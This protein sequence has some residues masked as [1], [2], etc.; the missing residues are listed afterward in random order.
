MCPSHCAVRTFDDPPQTKIHN[1]PFSS[2]H[3]R[4]WRPRPKLTSFVR[5]PYNQALVTE[6]LSI[7]ASQIIMH[8]RHA[9][10]ILTAAL[11]AVA[12]L[13]AFAVAQNAP[14]G[15]PTEPQPKLGLLQKLNPGLG[16]PTDGNHLKL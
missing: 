14:P 10:P 3:Q 15:A 8:F 13:A 6:R 2:P 1:K 9:I 16:G 12:L 7:V 11:A 4:L 5:R